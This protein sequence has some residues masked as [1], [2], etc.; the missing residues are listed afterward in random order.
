MQ[1]IKRA[2]LYILFAYTYYMDLKNILKGK[3]IEGLKDIP[4][5]IKITKET[6]EF[7]K[8]NNISPTK[9]FDSSIEE[10]KERIKKEGV[11]K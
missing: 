8:K 9:V 10:L 7:L 11:W 5:S 3:K 1:N 4:K 2:N 6:D